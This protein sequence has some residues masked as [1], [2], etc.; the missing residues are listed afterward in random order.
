MIEQTIGYLFA[1]TISIIRN[2]TSVLILLRPKIDDTCLNLLK[3]Y[4]KP[5]SRGH[6]FRKYHICILKLFLLMSCENR[7]YCIMARRMKLKQ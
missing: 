2:I 6:E 1:D 7:E 3:K 4:L 5:M